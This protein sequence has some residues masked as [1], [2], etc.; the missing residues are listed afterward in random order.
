M[1][2]KI[3]Y[4]D[5]EIEI[6]QKLKDFEKNQFYATLAFVFLADKTISADFLKPFTE[7]KITI[8]GSCA[9]EVILNQEKSRH[10]VVAMLLNIPETAFQLIVFQT[11]KQSSFIGQQIAQAAQNSYEHS[12]VLL[13]IASLDLQYSPEGVLQGIS[14]INSRLKVFGGIPSSFGLVEN[15]PFITA[16]GFIESGV[17]ALILNEDVLTLD[18]LSVSGWQELGT[19]KKITR[20]SGRKVYE[21]ENIPATEFYARYFGFNDTGTGIIKNHIDPDL[22]SASEYPL[23]LQRQDGSFVMRV[24]VQMDFEEKSVFFGGD[25]P[26]GAMVKFC[27]PNTIETIQHSL[28]D[29]IQFRNIESEKPDAILM[30]NCAVRSRSL[31]NFM[32]TELKA[33]HQIW[34]TPIV[35]FSSW[36]EIGNSL[37][38]SCGFHNT[39]I[40]VVALRDRT[41]SNRKMYEDKTKTSLQDFSLQA[42]ESSLTL[43]ELQKE[44]TQLRRDKKVLTHFLRLTNNDLEIEEARS[45]RL[46]L[47][48]LP[49]E[50]ATRLKAGET[51]IAQHVESASVLFADLTG[52]TSF[53]AQTDPDSLVK[54]LNEIFTAF[55]DFVIGTGVEKIK[56]IGDAYMLAAGVPNPFPE[57]AD[58]C[59]DLGR[60]MIQFIHDFSKRKK[61]SL[62]LRVG[63]NSGEVTAGVIGKH[64]FSYDLWG[65]TVNMAQR[66]EASAVPGSIQITTST[67][68]LLTDKSDFTSREI[69]VKGIGQTTAYILPFS[70]FL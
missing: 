9:A 11:E 70:S 17:C 5:S 37:N 26:Q 23:M 39:V 43:S 34:Q 53:S 28:K 18:G 56:T 65:D 10:A 3:V 63:I 29:M 8:F 62:N 69:D 1:D 20:S 42:P 64:K 24:A 51:N 21:I 2:F 33:I 48:I 19:P 44:V 6:E 54:M 49:A 67:F 13:L 46:L 68:K 14:E 27:S 55:D 50:T 35:G 36:G 45:S 4:G 47:N 7:R 30:F 38:A 41:T 58:I 25:I 12:S 16:E 31:G 40:S 52:F 57:H 15:P 22:L 60:Q 66:M 32:N 61:L 59:V